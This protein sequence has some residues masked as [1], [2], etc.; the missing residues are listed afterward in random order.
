[1]NL[2]D[3]EKS[4]KS[5]DTSLLTLSSQPILLLPGKVC[6]EFEGRKYEEYGVDVVGCTTQML[7]VPTHVLEVSISYISAV[8]LTEPS[9]CQR[10]SYGSPTH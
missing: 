8:P 10:V 5:T 1:M 6:V 4:N 2:V 9:P 3:I 7:G